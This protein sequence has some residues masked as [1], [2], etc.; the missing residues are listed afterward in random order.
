AT[1]VM[2]ALLPPLPGGFRHRPYE[3]PD[4]G[5]HL[6]PDCIPAALPRCSHPPTRRRCSI[7][8]ETDPDC[9]AFPVPTRLPPGCIITSC[10]VSN[11]YKRWELSCGKNYCYCLRTFEYRLCA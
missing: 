1:A 9:S 3:A 10:M 4:P 8:G 6:W 5:I 7:A 2:L 11:A